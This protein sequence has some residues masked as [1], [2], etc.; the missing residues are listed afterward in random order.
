MKYSKE[1]I[2]AI[3]VTYNPSEDFIENLIKIRDQ[4]GTI[5]IVDNNSEN[6][7]KLKRE[8]KN[9]NE[10]IML[11]QNYGIAKALNEGLNYASINK[12]P[13]SITFDQDSTIPDN[14][15][16]CFLDFINSSDNKKISIGPNYNNKR[17]NGYK[18]VSSLITSGNMFFTED[19]KNVGMFTEKLFIDS[20]DFDFSLKL[21]KIGV[22]LYI[23]DKTSMIHKIGE[24]QT[25]KF[26][27][28]NF[29]ISTHSSIRHYYAFRNNIYLTKKYIL[30]FPFFCIKKNMLMIIMFLEIMILHPNKRK[31]FRFIMKGVFHGIIGKYGR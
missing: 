18:K 9:I 19:A 7:D 15:I 4:V 24:S 13:L 3:I 29:N 25:V 16:N 5:I 14:Y 28:I 26:L 23:L 6:L 8:I 1:H 10:I 22:D 30:R 21:R 17:I 11:N 12:Y 20:V 2:C 31:N 27:L